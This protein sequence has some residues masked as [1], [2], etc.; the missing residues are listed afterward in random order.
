MNTTAQS[1]NPGALTVNGPWIFIPDLVNTSVPVDGG[2]LDAFTLDSAVS[3]T[4]SGVLNSVFKVESTLESNA[5]VANG[6]EAVAIADFY[7]TGSYR[8]TALDPAT[9][10]PLADVTFMVKPI[11]VPA[12]STW[13]MIGF[14]FVLSAA[15]TFATRRRKAR[16]RRHG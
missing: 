1:D 2:T 16:A 5:S 15:G 4:V 7:N 14:A 10:A 8:L 11:A 12:V 13:G 6:E 9:G 3:V